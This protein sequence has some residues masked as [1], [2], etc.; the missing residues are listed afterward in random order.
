M[1]NSPPPAYSKEYKRPMGSL[2]IYPAPLDGSETLTASKK[3]QGRDSFPRPLPR[4]PGGESSSFKPGT[5]SPLR[6]HKK[7]QSTVIERPWKPPSLDG[8]PSSRWDPNVPNAQFRHR[9][10][11][12]APSP[13]SSHQ[14]YLG[15]PAPPPIPLQDGRGGGHFQTPATMN[16]I[17]TV[18][19]DRISQVATVDA[20][21]FYNP[22]VSGYLTRPHPRATD[23]HPGQ[24][25]NNSP[26]SGRHVRWGS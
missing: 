19:A 7:S 20:N 10:A 24:P 15:R 9:E 21:S 6:V 25:S 12:L 14:K 1:D 4:T 5:V 3:A 2:N 23:S 13:L 17:A 26:S 8:R 18:P 11:E 16:K 22:A